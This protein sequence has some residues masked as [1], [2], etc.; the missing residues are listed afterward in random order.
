MWNNKID[1]Y[2]LQN[3]FVFPSEPFLHV[4]INGGDIL[5]VCL[6][7]DDLIYAGTNANMVQSFNNY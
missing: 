5:M 1:A 3:E 4:K 6:Y 7:V 2:F